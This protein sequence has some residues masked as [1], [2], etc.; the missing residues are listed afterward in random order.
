MVML[1]SAPRKTRSGQLG[2]G[3]S[4][5]NSAMFEDGSKQSVGRRLRQFHAPVM[6]TAIAPRSLARDPVP[7]SQFVPDGW[8]PDDESCDPLWCFLEGL[9]LAGKDSISFE[10]SKPTLP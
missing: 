1:L 6:N 7:D 3:W 8:L 10:R 4:Y 5:R 9:H 2:N